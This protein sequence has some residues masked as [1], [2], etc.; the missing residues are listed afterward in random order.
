MT[1]AT[2]F[3]RH[4]VAPS[5]YFDKTNSLS[6]S[7]FFFGPKKWR[8]NL[9]FKS[10][11]A[12][13]G[14][15]GISKPRTINVDYSGV[16]TRIH[17]LLVTSSSYS[18]D[19]NLARSKLKFYTFLSPNGFGGTA[20]QCSTWNE[21]LQHTTTRDQECPLCYVRSTGLQSALIP[22]H[23]PPVPGDPKWS[24]FQVLFRPNVA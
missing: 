3:R 8:Q 7:K 19:C 24:P 20:W 6:L 2:F 13:L 21:H 4:R 12:F 15:F 16:G 5:A 9:K 18:W 17:G 23:M 10:L 22:M 11:A 14:H 1:N